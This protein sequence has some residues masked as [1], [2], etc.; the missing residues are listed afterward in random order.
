MAFVARSR[1]SGFT[2]RGGRSVRE[3]VWVG[4]TF[5][6]DDINTSGV[7]LSSSFSTFV[8]DK[9]PF[10]IV[11]TRGNLFMASDQI[12][13]SED[14]E[15]AYGWAVVSEQALAIG[16]TAVPTPVTDSD[17]DLWF[18]YEP[19]QSRMLVSSAIGVVA[20]GG[21]GVSRVVD[22][23]AMRKVEEGQQVVGVAEVP[24]TSEGIRLYSYFRILI[25]L[26]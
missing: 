1:K 26:H 4:G 15:C 13:T 11:R 5:I 14:Q 16:V 9:A 17:S 10:T 6:Q 20:G 25:K 22:S 2:L 12:V 8:T 24:S 18:V 3:T 19:L 23:K 7:V 21:A